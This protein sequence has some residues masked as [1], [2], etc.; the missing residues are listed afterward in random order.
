M[1]P[2]V[3]RSGTYTP[4]D[5]DSS[6]ELKTRINPDGSGIIVNEKLICLLRRQGRYDVPLCAQAL[7]QPC[8]DT[9]LPD[10]PKQ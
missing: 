6:T 2:K 7:D 4:L 9:L 1:E 3:L 5:G 8:G 10:G